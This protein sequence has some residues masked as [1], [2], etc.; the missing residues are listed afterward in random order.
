MTRKRYYRRNYN[1]T[2]KN[3]FDPIIFLLLAVLLIVYW[4][5]I[6]YIKPNIESIM[7]FLKIF[8]PIAL[9]IIWLIIY[10]IIKRK[11]EN[12][13]EYIESMPS[14]IL[15]LEKKIREFKP[16]RHYNEEKMYQVGLASFLQSN[17]PDLDIEITKDYSRPDIVMKN[18]AIE[19]KWPTDMT[20]LKSLP[21][22]INSY[23]PKREY[24]FIVLFNIEIVDNIE[25]NERIYKEKKQQIIDNMKENKKDKVVFIEI[26]S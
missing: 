4:T 11:K 7:F 3:D 15:D 17:Y 1:R 8:I 26:N 25:E 20:W 23:L 13:Q 12:E 22:K 2:N 14:S 5:Y 10:Y 16:L 18:I 19:I 24:L 9:V 6:Q 21:D